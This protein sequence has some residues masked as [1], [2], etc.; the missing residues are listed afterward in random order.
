MSCAHRWLAALGA[1]LL[2]AAQ[3]ARAAGRFEL[4]S[5]KIEAPEMGRITQWMLR[6][7]HGFF[8]FMV[9]RGTS[10]ETEAAK[11]VLRIRV[12]G[13]PDLVVTTLP[14]TVIDPGDLDQ[15]TLR[16][17]VLRHHPGTEVAV[18]GVF[19]TESEQGFFFDLTSPRD[20]GAATIT[21]IGYARVHGALFEFRMTCAA[22]RVQ[23]SFRTFQD[24]LTSFQPLGPGVNGS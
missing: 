5:R 18:E 14:D 2:L 13:Q 16:E 22:N 20:A 15:K 24:F 8:G 9:P 12:T 10:L 6:T 11:G 3:P 21:R 17:M 19:H 1:G 7:E 23:S 4:Q